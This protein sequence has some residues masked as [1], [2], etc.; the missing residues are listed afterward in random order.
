MCKLVLVKQVEV[1]SHDAVIYWPQCR[2]EQGCA[3]IP[4]LALFLHNT[5]S[6]TP[7]TDFFD[8]PSCVTLDDLVHKRYCQPNGQIIQAK[9]MIQVRWDKHRLD[10]DALHAT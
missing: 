1:C 3:D 4:L 10:S 2:R 7:D 8:K 9:I 5:Q 6:S